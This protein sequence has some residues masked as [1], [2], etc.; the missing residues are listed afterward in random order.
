MLN[1]LVIIAKIYHIQYNHGDYNIVMITIPWIL[2]PMNLRSLSDVF[3]G[4]HSP[5]EI[6][7][8]TAISLS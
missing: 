6:S 8:Q 7:T 1:T 5:E 2:Y 3:K 4:R